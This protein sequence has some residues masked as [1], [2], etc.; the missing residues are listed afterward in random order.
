MHEGLAGSP[1]TTETSA[2]FLL[3]ARVDKTVSVSCVL[4]AQPLFVG[5][6]EADRCSYREVEKKVKGNNM[7]LCIHKVFVGLLP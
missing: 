2:I 5:E 7:A 3:S 6:S 1:N 4:C